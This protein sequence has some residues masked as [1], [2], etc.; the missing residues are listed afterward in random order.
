MKSQDDGYFTNLMYDGSDLNTQLS[1]DNYD[2]LIQYSN[3]A[4][5]LSQKPCENPPKTKKIKQCSNFRE[6]ED[7]CLIEIWINTSVDASWENEQK[8]EVS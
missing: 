5:M 2:V 6:E 8:R 1:Q 4:I 7:I 3:Q